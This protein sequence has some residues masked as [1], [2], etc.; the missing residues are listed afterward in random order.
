MALPICYNVGIPETPWCAALA[1]AEFI[2]A[3]HYSVSY[4]LSP[5]ASNNPSEVLDGSQK[6][7]ANEGLGK[8]VWQTLMITRSTENGVYVT[9][10]NHGG[11]EY[12]SMMAGVAIL[13]EPIGRVRGLADEGEGVVCADI[14]REA[15]RRTR[16]NG[17]PQFSDHHSDLYSAITTE[18]NDFPL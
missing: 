10:C 15:F 18:M 14:N 2:V 17:S 8:T 12:D 16:I 7:V 6:A 3:P 1:G 9:A 5:D 4:H 11:R 13:V